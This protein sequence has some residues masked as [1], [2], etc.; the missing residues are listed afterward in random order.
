MN[1]NTMASS[2][3][4]YDWYIQSFE[5]L[6]KSLNGDSKSSFHALRKDAITKFVQLGFP[7]LHHEEWRF[8]NIA[9]I[10]KK[11]FQP[12]LHEAGEGLT[13]DRLEPL[14]LTG[15][16]SVR[17]VFVNGH[18]VSRL[19][20]IPSTALDVK[21]GSLAEAIR[22]GDSSVTEYLTQVA[23]I[24]DGAFIALST[25]F[26][27]DGAFIRVGD[28][29][30]LEN[31][32]EC[33]YLTIP[34]DR[35]M[36]ISPRSLF[37]VGKN[38]KVAIV[39]NYVG[40]GDAAYLDNAVTEIVVGE[41]SFLEHDRIEN[42]GR[43]AY[44]IG[45]VYA[46]QA[47]SSN[48]TSN[49]ISLGGSIIRNSNTAV[50]AGEGAEATL[51]GLSLGMGDQLI[52]NHTTIDHT[53]PHCSSHEL[54]KSVLGG[55][56]RGVFNG[57]IFVRQDAQKTDA[58]QTNKTLLLSDDASINTKPQLEIFADDVKCTH[59]ATVGQ[60]DEEQIF[61]LRSRGVGERAAKDILTY[62]FASDVVERL[63]SEGL[64][65]QLRIRIQQRLEE[66]RHIKG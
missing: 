62:A 19:S 59:G 65:H 63:R 51:N 38:S 15:V 41:N 44:H 3:T 18:F 31:P 55:K 34:N 39:E 33:V 46:R 30:T 52:D 9:P 48:Y 49:T 20:A 4:E 11:K 50:L 35:L 12:V 26:V 61:Y 47:R 13:K 29:V 57:K 43:H 64:K 36:M 32:V 5:S 7:S 58:K 17:L 8:T 42:E 28:N 24:D 40:E 56:A 53:V 23:P 2:K 54:Y 37:V 27:L 21:M 6:E 10:R 60:L 1:Q 25:A 22:A 16:E 45:T 14:F 66:S